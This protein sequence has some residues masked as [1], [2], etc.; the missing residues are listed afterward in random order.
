MK[1][2]YEARYNRDQ[3]IVNQKY[4]FISLMS[5]RIIV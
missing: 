1:I 2:D 5:S 3:N 4:L